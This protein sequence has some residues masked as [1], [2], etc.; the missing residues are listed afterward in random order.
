[1]TP[2]MF[3]IQAAFVT[4]FAQTRQADPWEDV[5]KAFRNSL[6]PE[7]GEPSVWVA[8]AIFV[9]GLLAVVIV[10]YII[11]RLMQRG[12]IEHRMRTPLRFFGFALRQLGVGRTDRLLLRDAA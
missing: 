7:K 10:L 8:A 1:M 3:R 11:A 6:P 9:S 5:Q 12:P 4:V 2:L